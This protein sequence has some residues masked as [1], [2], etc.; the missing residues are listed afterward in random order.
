MG[1][2]FNVKITQKSERKS[3]ALDEVIQL[4]RKLEKSTFSTMEEK[5]FTFILHG[6]SAGKLHVWWQTLTEQGSINI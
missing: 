1:R 6:L 5:F 2:S 3:D 4:I